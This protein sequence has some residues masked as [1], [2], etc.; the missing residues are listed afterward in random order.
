MRNAASGLVVEQPFDMRWWM[1]F[2]DPVLDQLVTQGLSTNHDVRI[3]VARVQQA[4]AVFD[5]VGAIGFL[6]WAPEPALNVAIKSCRASP[7][8]RRV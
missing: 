3:S 1:Q 8:S 4:R 2:D 7:R 5:E 6:P